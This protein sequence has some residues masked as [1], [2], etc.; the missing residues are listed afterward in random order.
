M[1]AKSSHLDCMFFKDDLKQENILLHDKLR[2]SAASP[3]HAL[4]RLEAMSVYSDI[5]SRG[6]F[7]GNAVNEVR[8]I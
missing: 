3:E 5:S 2:H 1:L 4:G 7:L 6:L 8:S